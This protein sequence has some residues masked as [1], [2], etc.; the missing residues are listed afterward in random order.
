[1]HIENLHEMIEDLTSCTKDAMKN[2]RSKVG[3][4]PISMVTDM[5][6]DLAEAEYYSTIVKAMHEADEEKEESEKYMLRQMKEDYG[7]D[8]KRHYDEYRYAD[9]RFAPKGSGSRRGYK[10]VMYPAEYYRDMDLM[11]KRMYTPEMSRYDKAR[12]MYEESKGKGNPQDEMRHLEN[13]LNTFEGELKELLPKMSQS[14]K[15]LVKNKI[16]AWENVV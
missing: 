9:G 3:D 10:E 5:I 1:M 12:K 13:L 7:E 15:N 2:N 4:Y 16:D 6:K 8:W 11:D 14:E